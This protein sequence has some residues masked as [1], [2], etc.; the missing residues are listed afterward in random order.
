MLLPVLV[1]APTEAPLTL[2]EAKDVLNVVHEEDDAGIS[3]LVEEATALLDGPKGILGRA[4]LTQT[5]RQSFSGFA[6]RMDLPLGPLKSVVSITYQDENDAQQTLATSIYHAHEDAFGPYVGLN[7]GE[8]WPDTYSRPDAVTIEFQCGQD[9]ANEVDPQIKRAIGFLI[10]HWYVNREAVADRRMRDVPSTF[11][12]MVAGV[13]RH[14][15]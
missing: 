3:A 10:A 15:V 2:A 5:W 14:S 9:R 8:A 11:N 1:T 12:L 4:V 13:T 6:D 7:D